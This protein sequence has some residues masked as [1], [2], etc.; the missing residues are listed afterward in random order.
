MTTN[1]NTQQ[2]ALAA[3]EASRRQMLLDAA[4][5]LLEWKRP[6]E[7]VVEITGLSRKEV[8]AMRG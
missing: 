6:V 1:G 8:E 5:T 4:R 3:I 2:T 7:E